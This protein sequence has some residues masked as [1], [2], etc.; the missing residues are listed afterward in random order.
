MRKEL[1]MLSALANSY[2]S[3]L[4]NKYKKVILNKWFWEV[5]VLVVLVGTFAYAF[6]CT[7]K[8]YKFTGKIKLH[9]P[10]VWQMGIGCRR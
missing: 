10:K 7:S 4:E 6:Y 2:F 9:W 8:G 1:E 3:M 5:V